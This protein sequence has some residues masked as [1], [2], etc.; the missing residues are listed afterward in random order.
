MLVCIA[1]RSGDLNYRTPLVGRHL[2]LIRGDLGIS[3]YGRVCRLD[4]VKNEVDVQ[5]PEQRSP[6]TSNDSES[7]TASLRA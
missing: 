3:L 6:A 7:S 2:R 5:V 1:R 4:V